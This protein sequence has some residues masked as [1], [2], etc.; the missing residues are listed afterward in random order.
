MLNADL[1]L[2][3]PDAIVW[4]DMVVSEPVGGAATP[5]ACYFNQLSNL[6]VPVVGFGGAGLDDVVRH[7]P[8]QFPPF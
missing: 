7:F 8:A 5:P 4:L 6:S 2:S 1:N 3:R